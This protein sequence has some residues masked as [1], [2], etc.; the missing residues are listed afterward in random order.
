MWPMILLMSH[1]REVIP[2]LQADN[3]KISATNSRQSADMHYQ[4]IGAD[5]MQRS[6]TGYVNDT[7]E[8]AEV[9]VHGQ[10]CVKITVTVDSLRDA[11]PDA[12]S[13]HVDD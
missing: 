12:A 7:C 4:A 11:K 3:Q 2:C 1:L 5:R 8:R 10:L 13:V 9:Q 6:A